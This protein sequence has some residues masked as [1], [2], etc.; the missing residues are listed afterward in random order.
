MPR[1]RAQ[2]PC[3]LCGSKMLSRESAVGTLSACSN[4]RCY[5]HNPEFLRPTIREAFEAMRRTLAVFVDCAPDP[6][7]RLLQ[8]GRDALT[9]AAKVRW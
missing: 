8:Q 4:P 3:T 1:K 7:P 5:C 2:D 6:P 9:M